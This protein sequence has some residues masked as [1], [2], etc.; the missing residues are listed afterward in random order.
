MHF[1]FE[2]EVLHGATKANPYTEI[3][4]LSYGVITDVLFY[5]PRGSVGLLGFN[6]LYHEHQLYPLN[7]GGWYRGNETT[8]AFNEYQPITVNPYELKAR[9]YN[10]DDTID[11]SFFVGLAVQRPEEMGREIPATS[12]AALEDLIGSEI[13]ED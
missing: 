5:L 3:L 8:I 2:V 12:L 9:A 13:V 10:I 4:P 11:H 6:L 1:F 7:T